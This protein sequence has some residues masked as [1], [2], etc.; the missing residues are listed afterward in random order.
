MRGCS[1]VPLA[2]GSHLLN[3]LL[4]PFPHLRFELVNSNNLT[5]PPSLLCSE[6]N[7]MTPQ[8]LHHIRSE[9]TLVSLSNSLDERSNQTQVPTAMSTI[10]DFRCEASGPGRMAWRV[11][12]VCDNQRIHVSDDFA[13]GEVQPGLPVTDQGGE[14]DHG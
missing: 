2:R 8:N 4:N 6:N 3:L 7:Q 5:L 10:F 9:H 1:W 12:E 11:L 13:V 14:C